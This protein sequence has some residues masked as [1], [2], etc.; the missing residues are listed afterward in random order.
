M[1]PRLGLGVV[2][3]GW[4][5][6]AHSRSA[7]RIS[8]LFPDRTFDVDLVVCGD[9][10]AGR[11]EQATDGFGFRE[12]VDSWHG[13]VDHS[14]VDVVYVTAPNMLHEEV[15]CAAASAGKAVFCEKP[16]GGKPDQ[17]VRVDA[18]AR[19][20]GV[21]TG[22]GYNYRWAP[23]VQHAKQL[24]ESGALGEIT[25]YRGRFFSM[26]G[27]DPMGLLSWRFLVDEAGHGVSS[28]ILSHAV[29]LA[30]MLVGPITSVSGTQETFIKERPLPRAGGTHYDRGRPDDP[31]GAVTNEDYAAAM[32]VFDN[33]ARGTF[34]SSRAIIGPE[35]QMAF[36]V[37]GTKGALRWNL[38]TMNEMDVF[39]V[40]ETGTAP[41]GYTK[42]Y[43]GDRY[44][45][46]GHFVP[47]DANSIGYEDLKV[48]ENHEFLTAVAAGEQHEPGFAQAVE[49]VS[50]QHAWLRSCESGSWETVTSIRQEDA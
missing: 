7:A 48:I 40:D 33:G 43:A 26:Y 10:V 14:D 49:Y 15:A 39:L 17:T 34:E 41:R 31:T 47:G 2:G 8:S 27:A 28:D 3:F 13:V 23:L 44:P 36:D 5:G 16:V 6:Q 21:V 22:V 38:E 42:V 4:M 25:N 30:H 20:A 1:R 12:S 37:Y 29:D 19:R 32:V 45:F 11:R 24:I 9:N 18:A 35:S 50:F 46:H